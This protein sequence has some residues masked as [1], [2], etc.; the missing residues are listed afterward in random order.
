MS[1]GVCIAAVVACALLFSSCPTTAGAADLVVYAPPVDAAVVDPFRPPPNRFGAGNRGLEY[2]TRPG[3]PVRAAAAG[4]VIFAGSVAG[5]RHVTLLHAD[6]LRTSYSFL[7]VVEV[8]AGQRVRRGEVVGGS[9]PRLHFGVR[10]PDDTYLDPAPLF[11]GA[12]ERRAR[13]VPGAD[14]GRSALGR[15]ERAGFL[16][17]VLERAAG[18]VESG[19]LLAHYAVELRADVRAAHVLDRLARLRAQQ[20]QCTSVDQ[21]ASTP[22]GRRIAVLVGGLG[23]TGTRAAVDEVDT[24]ALG[25]SPADVVRFSYAGGRVPDPTDD[26][27]FAPVVATDYPGSATT[28]DLE[29]AAARLA[30]L[31]RAVSRVQPGVPVDVIAHSQGGVIARLAITGAARDGGLP[32]EVATLATIATPHRGA[33]LATA[34]E[35]VRHPPGLV[36]LEALVRSAGYD[37]HAPSVAQLSEVAP[38]I[39]RLDDHDLPDDIHRVSIAARGDLVVPVPRT[40]DGDF[41][42]AVVAL[43][44]LRA[45]DDLPGSPAVTRELALVIGGRPP[46]CAAPSELLAD[47]LGGEAVS[48]ATDALA[49]AMLA[50]G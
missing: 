20:Q 39:E 44:G 50:S 29:L 19:R 40:M 16:R 9:G 22:G 18:G 30:D 41:P 43:G 25:F 28:A 1:R 11:T 24:V 5:T 8:V 2:A 31:L 33:D 37:P 45:H 46:T 49:A 12:V 42:T 4:E 38:L 35:A 23:S 36:P 7:A 32:T 6:G 17:L 21:P 10:A 15:S 34:A 47:V 48:W 13:L 26:P 14:E 27:R 3:T